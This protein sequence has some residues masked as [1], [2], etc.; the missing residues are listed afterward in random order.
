MSLE[1]F[2]QK[3]SITVLFS[4]T[5]L[6]FCHLSMSIV[7]IRFVHTTHEL[8]VGMYHNWLDFF[9]FTI[10]TSLFY[11]NVS[12]IAISGNEDNWIFLDCL[13]PWEHIKIYA[14]LKYL[15]LPTFVIFASLG[16]SFLFGFYNASYACL[17]LQK[18]FG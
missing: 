7:F 13:L 12:N 5:S 8:I 18:L 3:Y 15:G 16:I 14:L 17:F 11:C 9:S 1:S 2:V 10:S 6:S 4:T